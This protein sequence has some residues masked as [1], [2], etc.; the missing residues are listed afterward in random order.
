MEADYKK[1]LKPKASRSAV[2]QDGCQYGGE[3]SAPLSA[4]RR[5][6]NFLM[7]HKK[8]ARRGKP[9][10]ILFLT[11]D[12][13]KC[14]GPPASRRLENAGGHLESKSALSLQQPADTPH[15]EPYSGMYPL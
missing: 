8:T 13:A 5:E 6:L 4:D 1:W 10:R 14:G 2:G 15:G 12:D 11:E 7:P 9:I 3:D